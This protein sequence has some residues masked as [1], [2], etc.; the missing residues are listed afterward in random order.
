MECKDEVLSAEW[1]YLGDI[2]TAIM[3]EGKFFALSLTLIISLVPLGDAL[4]VCLCLIGKSCVLRAVLLPVLEAL[5][6][7]NL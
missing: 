3:H 6:G 5:W 2:C 7:R 4:R 1:V